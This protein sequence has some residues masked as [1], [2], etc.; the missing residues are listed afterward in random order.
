MADEE[1]QTNATTPSASNEV[2]A[3][4]TKAA[5]PSRLRE[6]RPGPN[7]ES[8]PVVR[9]V[10]PRF[11]PVPRAD[12]SAEGQRNQRCAEPLQPAPSPPPPHAPSTNTA[13]PPPQP[14]TAP[15]PPAPPPPP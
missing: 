14:T 2:V 7:G 5:A 10:T 3:P 12:Q 4:G 15:A 11:A 8:A 13:L 6:V 1:A 9:D